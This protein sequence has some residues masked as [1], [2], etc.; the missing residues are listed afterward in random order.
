MFTPFFF[1][2]FSYI[3]GLH[4]L[5]TIPVLYYQAIKLY[6]P[7]TSAVAALPETLTVAPAAVVVGIAS[8]IMGR[9]RWALWSGWAITILGTGLLHLLDRHSTVPQWIF[10]N[11]PVG[12]GTGMV[13]PASAL[14]IQAACSP[15][16]NADAAAFFS[17]LRT[18]GQSL[19]VA[20][21]GTVF[22]NAFR[23]QLEDMPEFAPRAGEL[24]REA[25]MV[26]GL[27]KGMPDG[28]PK[29][30]LMDAYNEGLRILWI[31]L[32]AL[33]G[34]AFLLS[35]T[36]RGYT[37]QQEHVSKQKLVATQKAADEEA[38]EKK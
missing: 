26:V 17:F 33:A 3:L 32:T 36:V 35:L 29:E 7:V 6:S 19:G 2:S 23:N 37:L 22:Q 1:P 18:F 21:S 13:F 9:Y 27:I 12:I 28:E 4:T 38:A 25:T 8:A 34:V 15:R 30:K 24:S 20:V 31:A 14:A 11:L 5:T 10:L 16:L